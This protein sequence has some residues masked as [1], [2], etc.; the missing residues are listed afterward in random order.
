MRQ[1]MSGSGRAAA[2][3]L[4][5]VAL[6]GTMR[7]LQR[8]YPDGLPIPD[9]GLKFFVSSAAVSVAG[10]LFWRTWIKI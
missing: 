2:L 9:W 6:I 8:M 10:W 4:A 7:V 5:S 3:A 1:K